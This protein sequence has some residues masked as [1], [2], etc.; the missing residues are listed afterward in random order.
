[1]KDSK[2]NEFD[3]IEIAIE[4]EDNIICYCLIPKEEIEGLDVMGNCY[5]LTIQ[6]KTHQ[7][8]SK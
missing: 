3:F 5:L 7:E 4:F 8:V 1:M 6:Q 2:E